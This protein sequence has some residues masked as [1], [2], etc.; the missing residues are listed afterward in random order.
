MM[1]HAP[2]FVGADTI[3]RLDVR[4]GRHRSPETLCELSRSVWPR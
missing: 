3:D 4:Q 1:Y 2:V